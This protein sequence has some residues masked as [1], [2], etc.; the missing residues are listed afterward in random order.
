MIGTREDPFFEGELSP[1]VS[2]GGQSIQTS[3]FAVF[4]VFSLRPY[5]R[6]RGRFELQ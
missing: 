3:D 5:L 6:R 1:R 2:Y 4:H